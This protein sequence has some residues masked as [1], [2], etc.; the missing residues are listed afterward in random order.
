MAKRKGGRISHKHSEKI[1]IEG[2]FM[3]DFITNLKTIYDKLKKEAQ[4]IHDIVCVKEQSNLE[5]FENCITIGKVKNETSVNNENPG[6]YVF[7]IIEEQIIEDFD[8]VEYGAKTNYNFSG[9][10]EEGKVLYLGKAEDSL[11][12]RLEEHIKGPS[13]KNTYSLRLSNGTR[14]RLFGKIALYIFELKKEYC[15]YKKIILSTVESQLHELCKP[16][17][18]TSR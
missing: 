14:N 7:K 9:R 15:D 8:S 10:F 6:I 1:Q 5:L 12:K 16:V 3:C 4:S 2:S 18:G 11:K 13:S 17:V